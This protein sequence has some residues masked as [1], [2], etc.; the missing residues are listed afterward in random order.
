MESRPGSL[1]A[2]EQCQGENPS[3]RLLVEIKGEELG[4]SLHV[5]HRL[6]TIPFSFFHYPMLPESHVESDPKGTVFNIE[7]RPAVFDPL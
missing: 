5:V 7:E 2:D 3:I 4:L 1:V 6:S